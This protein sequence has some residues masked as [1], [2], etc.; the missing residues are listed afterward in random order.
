MLRKIII[1]LASIVFIL[2][3]AYWYVNK[4]MQGA[5]STSSVEQSFTIEAGEGVN[6]ISQRLE[7]QGLISNNIYF[8]IYIWKTK[9]ED[10]IV[11]GTYA[12]RPNM[13]LPEII[14]IITTGQA[15][16]KDLKITIIE[17][18]NIDNIGEYL[19]KKDIVS[20]EEFEA[21]AKNVTKYQEKYSFLEGLDP[22]TNTLEG[23]L[24]PDTYLLYPDSTA[25]M[26]V[27][28]MLNN[29]DKKLTTTMRED[30]EQE[31]HT[32]LEAITMASIIEREVQTPKDQKIIS[33]IFWSRLESSHPLQSCATIN[34]ILGTN[35]KQLSFDDTRVDSPYNTYIN[36][37][38]PPGPI[39]NPGLNA[40]TAAIYPQ[41]SDYFYFLSNPE[42]GEIIY[43]RTLEEHNR[44]KDEN[45]L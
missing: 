26:I 19:A 40:I 8:D 5:K 31:G 45:G 9:R 41:E 36:R 6:Q 42:T 27:I 28:R 20:K 39:S 18:W 25:E 43:A 10:K 33:G 11:T 16:P 44:N 35:K 13:T 30:L 1:V 22:E 3:G 14:D 38:L 37:G 24:F 23:F 34:Y 4:K 21:E 29:F 17:G 32:F 15:E 2:S 12:L 7:D